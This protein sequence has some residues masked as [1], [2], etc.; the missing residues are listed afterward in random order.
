MCKGSHGATEKINQ[1]LSTIKLFWLLILKENS[2]ASYCPLKKIMHN[3]KVRKI[4]SQKMPLPLWKFIGLSL[5]CTWWVHNILTTVMMHTCCRQEYRQ[6]CQTT[7]D[8]LNLLCLFNLFFRPVVWYQ[9]IQHGCVQ[10]KTNSEI[11]IFSCMRPWADEVN[12]WL[13]YLLHYGN[14]SCWWSDVIVNSF[15]VLFNMNTLALDDG[16][17]ILYALP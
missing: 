2:C 6:H 1:L 17:V 15:H 7:F 10:G 11:N 5:G 4:M 3:L 13:V 16:E 9:N 8:L 12:S 14:H